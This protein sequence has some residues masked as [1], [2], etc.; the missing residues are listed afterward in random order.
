[1][2]NTKFRDL[3]V[4]IFGTMIYHYYLNARMELAKQLLL[5][6]RHAVIQVAYKVGF[7]RSQSFAKAFIKLCI[8]NE[9]LEK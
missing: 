5:T 6:D 1:M 2:S 8:Q 9:I 3:F 7:T 4:T